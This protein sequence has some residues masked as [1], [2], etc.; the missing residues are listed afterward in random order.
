MAALAVFAIGFAGGGCKL[1]TQGAG[2][3][4]VPCTSTQDCDDHNDCTSDTCGPSGVCSFTPGSALV[5]DDHNDCTT[6]AC[7][8]TTAVHEP[9]FDGAPCHDG[10][11]AGVCSA[12]E[13]VVACNAS[14]QEAACDDENPCTLDSCDL[15]SGRCAR[16]KLNDTPVPGVTQTVGDCKRV[17]CVQ[18]LATEAVDD[19][20]LP[21]NTECWEESCS[22]GQPKSTPSAIDS[23]CGWSLELKCDG[24]GKC[25]GCTDDGQCPRDDC[26]NGTCDASGVCQLD[27]KPSGTRLPESLQTPN[28]CQSLQCDGYGVAMA[29]ADDNDLPVP[30]ALECT[31]DQCVGGV[32]LHPPAPKNAACSEGAGSFCDGAGSCVECN[33]AT[34]CSA[35][36]DCATR[37][38]T[39]NA[40]VF[41]NKTEGTSCGASGVCDGSGV[42]VGCTK[43]SDCPDPGD[44]QHPTCA[45][46]TCGVA[47]DP[48]DQPCTDG[49]CDG[50]GKCV[51][52]TLATQCGPGNECNDPACTSN[53]CTLK[54]KLAGT[55]CPSGVCNAAGSCVECIMDGGC[56]DLGECTSPVCNNGV[57]GTVNDDKSTTCSNGQYCDGA[58]HCVECNTDAQCAGG[59]VCLPDVCTNNHC[60]PGPP[61]PNGIPCGTTTGQQCDG[62]GAC[63]L[64]D[65][66]TCSS[67]DQ[68]MRGNCVDLVC[69]DTAC[70]GLCLACSAA[71]KGTGADG[72]CGPIKSG[73]DPDEE[74]NGSHTCDG[75]GACN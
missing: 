73:T 58:G 21:V 26:N 61:A 68:C 32:P 28:D 57:C 22:G 16:V 29:V 43:P 51:D 38:C 17:L 53:V 3:Y 4:D 50:T 8:G 60:E 14:N 13:C 34:Q 55:T 69:C 11:N 6:D 20:D 72:T 30:D 40:C 18:G 42:C 27:P 19:T 56:P 64:V 71:K 35:P 46:N 44:C 24:A 15:S 10:S 39:S 62:A 75:N 23:P 47:P 52:C 2:L 12:G 67:G 41:T 1:D 37:A 7:S 36:G 49:V 63:K 74:C 54:P 65:G 9:T 31:L 33:D 66:M 45:S 70:A 25:V 59:T 48:K 5:P